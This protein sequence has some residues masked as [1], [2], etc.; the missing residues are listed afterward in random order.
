ML[1]PQNDMGFTHCVNACLDNQDLMREY[2]RLTGSRLGLRPSTL[3]AMIDQAT[4]APA[5]NDADAVAFFV[6]VRDCI[7]QPV[8]MQLAEEDT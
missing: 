2:R 5:A 1:D 6:F 4:G 7:W 8:M 3:E